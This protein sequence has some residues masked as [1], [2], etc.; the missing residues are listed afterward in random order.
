[1][2][3]KQGTVLRVEALTNDPRDLKVYRAKEGEPDGPKAW[4]RLRKG[5][6]DLPRRAE[7]SQASTQRYL[8]SLASVQAPQRLGELTDRVCRPVAWQG[9]PVRALAPLAE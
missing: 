7:V 8:E 2:Y 9:R 1:M 5:V 6:A 4:R 3:D